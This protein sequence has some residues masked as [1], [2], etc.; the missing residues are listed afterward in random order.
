MRFAKRRW[1]H[2]TAAALLLALGA[3]AAT[4]ADNVVYATADNGTTNLFG[5]MDLTTGQFTQIATTTPLFGSLTQG[6]GGT[7]YGGA[8]NLNLNLYAISPSGTPTQLGTVTAPNDSYGF[9]GLASEGAAGFFGVAQV[10]NIP[11]PF[12]AT[13]EHIS[14][15]GTSFNVVGT[16]GVSFGSFNS[17]N[18]AFGPNGT[19]YFD[20]WNASFVS[21]LYALNTSTGLATAVG[22][23]LGSTDP[24]ALVSVG[25]TLY[26]INT[27]APTH[28]EIYTI[29]TTTGV[30]TEIGTVSGLSSGFTLDTMAGTVPEP[31]S[32]FLLGAGTLVLLVS[33]RYVQRRSTHQS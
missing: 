27:F 33:S 22:S 17:G 12:S 23:G 6:Q 19:L 1:F 9:T 25:S 10:G 2:R 7:L 11:G 31:S 13:L 5:T 30:A 8:G 24:L 29:N 21:T 20:A 16:M 32:I 26:G 4:R 18:L 3:T 14:A 15:D 28:P